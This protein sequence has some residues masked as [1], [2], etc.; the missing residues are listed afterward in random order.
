MVVALICGGGNGAHVA[1]GIAAAQEGVEAR[2]L[3]L[4]ADEAERWTKAMS[5][6]DFTVTL[7]AQGK[8]PSTLKA[9]PSL[10]TKDPAL[11]MPG[12]T[13]IIFTVPAF[14]HEQYLNGLKPHIKPGMVLAGCPGQA[15]FEFAVRGIWG[16]VTSHVSIMSFESLPWACRM[17]DFGKAAEVLGTKGSLTG[18]VLP[19][20]PPA[21]IDPI[22]QLQ[23]V[24]GP[25]P[26][27]ISQGHLLGIT[28]MGTNG[29]LHPSITYGYW[30]KWDGKGVAEAPLFYNGLDRFS[31]EILSK[32]SQ[33]V[34]DTAKALMA[35]RQGVQLA[36]VTHIYDW[37]LRCY[38][39]DIGD[40]T[41]LFSCIQTNRAYKGL[42]H[43]CEKNEDGT[44]RPNYGYRYMTED[45]PFGLVVMR[46]VAEIAGVATPNMDTVILWAQ[47]N[48]G[49]E[50]LKD[51]KVAGK[52]IGSTRSPQKYNLTTVDAI[53]GL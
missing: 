34:V 17:T 20:H 32:V 25:A 40:K 48:M 37:F 19:S 30:H 3:T 8:E 51:G 16:D 4:F 21:A 36:N 31:A 9:K 18:A 1:A 45:I 24:L 29:Y 12:V 7:H 15:G 47:S 52:D 38:S 10:V 23:K 42:V 28:L 26:K 49:K 6:S 2:V 50:Y 27:L 11:A 14:A 33:E 41:D 43:P 53:L 35:Q 39:E 13:I 22:E 5:T 44:Y 46:G